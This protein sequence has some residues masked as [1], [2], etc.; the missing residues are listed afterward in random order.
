[1]TAA[2]IIVIVVYLASHIGAGHTH[3]RYQKAQGLNPRLYD[4]LRRGWYGSIRLPG[5]W[6]VGHKL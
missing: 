6:R 2:I 3:Y 5:G 4:T 1:M